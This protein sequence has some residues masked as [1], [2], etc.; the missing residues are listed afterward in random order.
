MSRAVVIRHIAFEDLGVLAEVLDRRGYRRGYLDAGVDRVADVELSS[1]DLLIVLGGPI[2]AYE[3]QRYPF[4]RDLSSGPEKLRRAYAHVCVYRLDPT[5]IVMIDNTRGFG[6][7]S[8]LELA[9][10]PANP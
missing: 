10:T 2:G 9:G 4:L 3:E 7:K 6:H 8:V 5:S 1:D